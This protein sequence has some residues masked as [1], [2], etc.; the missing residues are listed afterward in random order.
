MGTTGSESTDSDNIA[1]SLV[2][3]QRFAAV[4][5]RHFAEIF[6]YLA[7][8]VGRDNAED[9]G[10]ETFIVAFGARKRYDPS[11]AN[12][13]PWLY[14]IATNL[15]R[16]H[17]R[18]E[19]RMLTAYATAASQLSLDDDRSEGLVARLDHAASL[20]RVASAFADLDPDQREAL[21][22]VAI[23]GL[24]YAQA[25]EAL[26]IPVG[27]VHSRVARARTNLRDLAAYSGQEGN[28]ESIAARES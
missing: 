21:Y 1:A 3:P 7:R 17:R 8:R 23:V 19:V 2:D 10:A 16:R 5:D 28:D 27:T 25:S 6:R 4:V 15:I 26:D 22:L 11:R 20:A 12:A 18:T 24:G 13:L 9:L 14:G